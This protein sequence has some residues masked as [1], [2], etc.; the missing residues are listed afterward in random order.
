VAFCPC[1]LLSCGLLSCGLMSVAFCPCGLLSGS[2]HTYRQ[3][4]EIIAPIANTNKLFTPYAPNRLYTR[5]PVT[6]RRR[7][8]TKL[9]QTRTADDMANK[10]ATSWQQVVVTEF[11]KRHDT[12]DTTDF[13]P[14]QL[15]TDLL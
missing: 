4:D 10:S 7:E 11:G 1:G 12:T 3:T 9:L 2:L 8:V 13:C 15:V 14:C 5:F 6:S